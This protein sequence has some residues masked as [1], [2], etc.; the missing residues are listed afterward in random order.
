MER[1]QNS[2]NRR[3]NLHLGFYPHR[4]KTKPR[5]KSLKRRK[6]STRLS[7]SLFHAGEQV[8]ATHNLCRSEQIK[9]YPTATSCTREPKYRVRVKVKER[10]CR[11]RERGGV[12][13]IRR[14][15]VRWLLIPVGV[16]F[17]CGQKDTGKAT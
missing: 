14:E 2:T 10:E 13:V 15:A 17:V 4:R 1:G 16:C 9:Q 3:S 12:N 8:S 7:L 11:E 6:T 5:K